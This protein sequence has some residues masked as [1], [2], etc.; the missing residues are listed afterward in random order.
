MFVPFVDT[1]GAINFIA[2]TIVS[3]FCIVA[4]ALKM[5]APVATVTSAREPKRWIQH[6]PARKFVKVVRFSR[7]TSLLEEVNFNKE[8]TTKACLALWVPPVLSKKHVNSGEV[9]LV[10]V[11][12]WEYATAALLSNNPLKARRA[13]KAFIGKELWRAWNNL[14]GV[15]ASDRRKVY[16]LAISKAALYR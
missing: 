13:R 7:L 10:D 6:V 16:A 2:L 12:N 4:S 5:H 8:I 3:A 1:L 15:S 9:G 14:E 11:L